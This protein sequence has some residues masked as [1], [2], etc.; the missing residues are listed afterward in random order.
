MQSNMLKIGLLFIP[1][2]GA[3][4]LPKKI[5]ATVWYMSNNG[6]HATTVD[7]LCQPGGLGCLGTS[8]RSFGR[9]LF[10]SAD[11]TNPLGLED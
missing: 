11:L 1:I 4:A 2:A 6:P 8:V 5:T 3:F 10:T 9:Q 7:V